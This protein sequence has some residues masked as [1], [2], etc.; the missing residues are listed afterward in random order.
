MNVSTALPCHT[1]GQGLLGSAS[2]LARGTL[3]EICAAKRLASA[4]DIPVVDMWGTPIDVFAYRSDVSE[5]PFRQRL[6][7]TA[8]DYPN[9]LSAKGAYESRY[10]FACQR[11]YGQPA[12]PPNEFLQNLLSEG[13][14]V[15]PLAFALWNRLHRGRYVAL[16]SGLLLD[17]ECPDLFG[18]TPDGL[19][20]DSQTKTLVG[21][22][23]LK[24]R[25]QAK[26][27]SERSLIPQKYFLQMIGQLMC[28][29]VYRWFYLELGPAGECF[30]YTGL[31]T[32]EIKRD[33]RA[34]LLAFKSLVA[35]KNI[36]TF[37]KRSKT[38]KTFEI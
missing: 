28:L 37:P 16:R 33:V 10:K 27:S 34:D 6:F 25:P 12:R 17:Q 29:P 2:R 24:Y 31:I 14:R 35:E 8:S 36:D 11:Y 4:G 21:T 20:F 9:A 19:V 26:L 7:L 5:N 13:R 32:E 1:I 38:Y 15:E 23:E 22:L 18:A 3:P 30:H